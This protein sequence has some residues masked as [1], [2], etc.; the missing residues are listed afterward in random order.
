MNRHL[1]AGTLALGLWITV[2]PVQAQVPGYSPPVSPYV[3]LRQGGATGIN[4]GI[5]YYGIV[6]PQLEFRNSIQQLQQ[7]QS[8]FDQDLT[9]RDQSSLLPPTGH[10]V[11]FL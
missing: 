6:R 10:H 4:P 3:N 5:N 8:A 7:Q 2:A 11:G 9:S 1:L